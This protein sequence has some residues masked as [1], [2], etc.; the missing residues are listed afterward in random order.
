MRT[1]SKKNK[2]AVSVS[3]AVAVLVGGGVAY[4]YWSTSGSGSGSGT[5]ESSVGP[6]ALTATFPTTGLHP[7]GSVP[8]TFH[9][10]NP[11][12]SDVMLGTVHAVVTT[13]P[14]LCLSTDFSMADVIANQVI[15]ASTANV[16][17]TSTG[18]LTFTNTSVS[19][20]ACKG[21]TV[22]LTLTA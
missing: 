12:T 5:T 22:T 2:A 3:T 11:S 15:P 7:G 13:N 6:L 17:V 20:D 1:L 21:A 14:S 16:L 18:V 19:Q 10:S 9:A 8:V 4:A